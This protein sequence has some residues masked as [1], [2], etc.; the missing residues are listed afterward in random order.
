MPVA[1]TE[2]VAVWPATTVWFAGCVVMA[3]GVDGLLTVR[4]ARLLATLCVE[5]ETMTPN[6]AR[7]S[8]AVVAGVVYIA[9][10]APEMFT[11]F[12]CH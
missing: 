6:F 3:G 12:F 1:T 10:V 11:A 8:E 9:E 5:C 4:V 2:K 7:L